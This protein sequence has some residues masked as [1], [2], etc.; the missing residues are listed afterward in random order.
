MPVEEIARL[1]GH[2]NSGASDLVYRHRLRPIME[3]AAE[4]ME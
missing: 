3:R 4:A 1:A 2:T